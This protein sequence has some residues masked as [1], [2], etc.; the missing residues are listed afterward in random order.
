MGAEAVVGRR[1]QAA[2]RHASARLQDDRVPRFGQ[3]D[4]Q[5]LDHL[6]RIPHIPAGQ[7]EPVIDDFLTGLG[8]V[9]GVRAALRNANVQAKLRFPAP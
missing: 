9:Q 2:A 3:L 6:R 8:F 5:F 7:P 1:G 4:V